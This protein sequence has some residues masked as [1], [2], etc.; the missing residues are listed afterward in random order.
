MAEKLKKYL[1]FKILKII[2]FFFKPYKLQI[3]LLSI[4]MLISGLIETLNMAVLYPVMNYGLEQSSQ[5]TILKVF[6]GLIKLISSKNMF[7]SSCYLLIII[8]LVSVVIKYLDYFF[9]YKLSEIIAARCQKDILNKYIKSNYDFFV[10]K[11][12]GKLIYTGTIAAIDTTN[13]ILSTIRLINDLVYLLFILSLLV[14]LTW[15]GAFLIFT[16]GMGYLFVV[17]KV[18]NKIIHKRGEF[19]MEA[20]REKNVILNEFIT[21]I[22]TIKVFM[23]FES[24]RKRYYSAVDKS[25]H[26]QF[27]MLMGRVYPESLMKLIFFILIAAGGILLSYR[28]NGNIL[29]WIPLYGT[30]ALV[31]SRL[32]PAI[33]VVGNDLLSLTADLP[34]T[35]S[36]YALLNEDSKP[37]PEGTRILH[38]FDREIAFC[39]VWF[40][41]DSAKEYLFKDVNFTIEKKKVTAF[42]G[43]SGYGKTTL[44]NLLLRLYHPDKGQIQIDGVDISEFTHKSYLTKIGYVSQETFLYNNTILENIKFGLDD[45]NEGMITD[46]AKQANAYEFIMNTPNG[47]D[48]VVGDAGIKLSGGE[49]QRIAIARAMLRKPEI[50]VLDEATSA[51]DNIAEKKVQEAINNIS[52]YTTVVVIAHRLSTIQSADKILVLDNGKIVEQGRH[53]TLLSK[54][55]TYYNLYNMQS[56]KI[57]C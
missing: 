31:I 51:L 22:K 27:L 56:A 3:F 10:R 24:W 7:L 14:I 6:N 29:P 16:I 54:K 44:I 20:G 52:Q 50:M 49:R 48:T 4:L 21:G 18:M 2:W 57:N 17:K 42:V 40:K 12:Q 28:T 32:F 15:Q 25:T 13:M 41:F 37:I 39:N 45:C 23:E 8:S 35:K 53:E 19:M 11:Q 55:G 26:N 33:Q 34:N 36:V 47:Y 38:S 5:G 1:D 30:F 46:A 9:S 43:P